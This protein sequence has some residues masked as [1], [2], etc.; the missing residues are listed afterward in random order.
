MSD[1]KI[2][3]KRWLRWLFLYLTCTV[4]HQNNLYNYNDFLLVLILDQVLCFSIVSC[5]IFL[6]S[7]AIS[8]LLSY[9]SSSTWRLLQFLNVFTSWYESVVS[10][11]VAFGLSGSVAQIKIERYLPVDYLDLL[12]AEWF[13]QQQRPDMGGYWKETS[14]QQCFDS[15]LWSRSC[16]LADMGLSRI[17]SLYFPIGPA[18]FI[19]QSYWQVHFHP[20]L[21][22]MSWFSCLC[23]L[24]L[25]QSLPHCCKVLSYP[26]SPALWLLAWNNFKCW[27]KKRL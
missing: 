24:I 11:K 25:T 10:Y 1:V 8:C 21:Q 20:L 16:W 17:N 4:I 18:S 23:Y 14:S 6:T 26:V 7:N 2:S 22:N 9:F 19:S 12:G 5:I 27:G 13:V 15:G 3:N